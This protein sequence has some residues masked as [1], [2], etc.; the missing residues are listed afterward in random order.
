MAGH[1]HCRTSGPAVPRCIAKAAP[2]TA[3]RRAPACRLPSRCR[4]TSRR[5]ASRSSGGRPRGATSTRAPNPPWSPAHS[6]SGSG[7]VRTRSGKDSATTAPMPSRSI[8]WW[9]S[10]RNCAPNRSICRPPR[11]CSTRRPA[12]RPISGPM[13]STISPSWCASRAAIRSRSCRRS[14]TRCANST[15][16]SRSS[17]RVR[18]SRSPLGRWLARRS[19]LP[20]SASPACSAWC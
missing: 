9:V 7:P 4:D 10:S 11:R 14:A 15:R 8:G 12:W 3:V 19:R 13:P 6:P 20:C 1:C 5:W 16:T 2:R 17:R 18:W